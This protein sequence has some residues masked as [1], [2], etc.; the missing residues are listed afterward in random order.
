MTTAHR[1]TFHNALG[2]NNSSNQPIPTIFRRARDEPG[3]LTLK[4]RE[5]KDAGS[6]K[7]ALRR[8]LEKKEKQAKGAIGKVEPPPDTA[9]PED[10]DEDPDAGGGGSDTESEADRDSSGSDDDEDEEEA[11]LMRELAKIRAERAAEEAKAAAIEQAKEEEEER[12]Q[13]AVGNPLL[14]GRMCFLS[15][16]GS[17]QLKR[18]WDDDTVFK[19]QSRNQPKGKKRF[20]ND[21]VRSDFHRKFL[22]RYIL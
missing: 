3:H 1:P 7:A 17:M 6:N 20:I 14:Q 18:R 4:F 16:G 8:E 15:A 12:Q 9:F 11:E 21:A 13:I 5:S 10:C 22:D 2:A 19:N